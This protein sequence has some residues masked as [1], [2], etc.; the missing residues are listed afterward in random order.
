MSVS[1]FGIRISCRLGMSVP[2][3]DCRNTESI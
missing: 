1:K 2:V 3:E